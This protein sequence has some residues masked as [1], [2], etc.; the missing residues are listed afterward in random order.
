[1]DKNVSHEPP[2]HGGNLAFAEARYGRPE[3]GWLDL[4]T[5]VNADPWPVP[6]GALEPV[7]RLPAAD[8]LERLLAAARRTYGLAGAA[9]IAAVPGSEIA[10]RL[11]P[12]IAPVG[13]VALVSPTYGSHGEAW[14][15]AG[16]S[17]TE[18][19]ALDALPGDTTVVVLGNPNNPDGRLV[20]PDRLVALAGRLG[21][22]GGLLVRQAWRR[23]P[24]AS[25]CSTRGLP[26]VILRS[27]GKFYGLPGLRLGFVGG[28]A[29]VV[30][31][32]AR[33]LGDWPV[34]APALAIGAAALSDSAW[35]AA[36]RQRLAA[37]RRRLETLLRAHGLAVIGATDLFVLASHPHAQVIHRSLARRGVWTR[38]FAGHATW[39]RLGLPHGDA[40]FARLDQSLASVSVAP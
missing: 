7:T 16:R 34:S 12:L 15:D 19:A 39:L 9:A 13:A 2:R 40:E 32:F 4:S 29:V 17:V 10:I 24:A 37:G 35:Q 18:I 25:L 27:L 26:A 36:T 21:E 33:L 6:D 28:T 22:R 3:E 11:L 38:A 14:R 5:G 31:P 23:A 8:A 20:A 30:E 1:M